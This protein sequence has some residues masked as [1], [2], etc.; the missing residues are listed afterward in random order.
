MAITK[1][2][3]LASTLTADD[4]ARQNTRL[5]PRI[6][7]CTLI[8]H[9]ASTPIAPAILHTA[10]TPIAPAILH[11]DPHPLPLH[12]NTPH[13]STALPLRCIA[14]LHREALLAK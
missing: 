1:V 14:L 12:A 7:G 8:L 10:S 3:S 4:I 5:P 13:R 6:F 9:T 2:F 11:T